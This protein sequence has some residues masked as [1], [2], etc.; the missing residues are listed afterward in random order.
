MGPATYL[1]QPRLKSEH[2]LDELVAPDFLY[3]ES[4]GTL[5]IRGTLVDKLAE[6][7]ECYQD[8]NTNAADQ[9]LGQVQDYIISTSLYDELVAPYPDI[10]KHTDPVMQSVAVGTDSGVKTC[11]LDGTDRTIIDSEDIDLI[12]PT[13]GK[14]ARARRGHLAVLQ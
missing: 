1:F 14:L 12:S 13:W 7:F 3:D 9:D 11:I 8:L 4:N 6:V 5:S 10:D 2:C